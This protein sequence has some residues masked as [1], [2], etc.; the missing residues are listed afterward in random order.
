MIE[1]QVCPCRPGLRASPNPADDRFGRP[2]RPARNSEIRRGRELGRRS[3]SLDRSRRTHDTGLDF[4][5]KAGALM[6][7]GT[8]EAAS[9]VRNW[10][11]YA[12]GRVGERRLPVGWRLWRPSG[13]RTAS[14][15]PVGRSAVLSDRCSAAASAVGALRAL[16]GDP[17]AKW[18]VDSAP[19]CCPAGPDDG[20]WPPRASAGRPKRAPGGLRDA[21]RILQ[22]QCV[23]QFLLAGAKFA[24]TGPLVLYLFGP[25][26]GAHSASPPSTG[27]ALSITVVVPDRATRKVTC[28]LEKPV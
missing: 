6:A 17:E 2:C 11:L 1:T 24:L 10:G 12:V 7:A 16:S 5:H 9:A 28:C 4:L 25:C 8:F 27:I 13:A 14:S 22:N 19:G 18:A 26:R 3:P 23:N 15:E 21:K 20:F